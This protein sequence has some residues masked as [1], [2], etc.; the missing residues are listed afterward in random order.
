MLWWD[1][2][3]QNWLGEEDAS[4]GISATAGHERSTGVEGHSMD[5]LIEFLSMRRD[6]L[7]ASFRLEVPNP[8]RA[9]VTCNE[10]QSFN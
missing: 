7:D 5:G 2:F 3:L 4:S 10:G 1:I 9:V 8:Q 6:L